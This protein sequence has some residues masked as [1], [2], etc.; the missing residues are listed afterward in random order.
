MSNTDT[1]KLEGNG[2]QD[3]WSIADDV[4]YLNHGSFGP[5]PRVVEQARQEWTDQLERQ[6]MNFF[7]R[8]MEEAL[9]EARETLAAFVGADADDLIFVDNA[10]YGMNIVAASVELKAGDEVLV[11]NHE[12]GAVLRVWRRLCKQTGAKLV[13]RKLPQPFVSANE[14]AADFLDGVTDKTKLIVVSHVTSPTALTLPV[15]QICHGARQ[16]GVQVCVDGP[17][18]IAMTPLS[19]RKLNCDYYAASCHK[20][21]SAPFGTGF[22]Y[23]A[24]RRQATVKPPIL[25]W[26][27][28]ISGKAPDWKDEFNWVGTRDPAGFLAI[29][30]A[31]KFLETTGIDQFRQSTHQMA[32]YARR[33]IDELFG[34][35]DIPAPDSIDWY[36]SMI[37]LP[38]TTG[39]EEQPR[40][41]HRDPLQDALWEKFRI[42]VPIVHWQQ[43]RFV[44]V[45]CHLYNS[46]ADID[47]LTDALRT[48]IQ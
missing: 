39:D 26:G 34:I 21:L 31:I 11:T 47:Q 5:S 35:G 29:P 14:T 9:T 36:A 28:S 18:A 3:A 25:S 7:L 43:R 24:G 2:M 40:E 20:W 27:G 13:V 15:K 30:A 10:T 48:L 33:Q 23:V 22:L 37:A 44:R 42:E 8:Q 4:T 17:H 45:S 1:L 32:E 16:R 38:I 12:Y 19:I 6:P 41:G 46:R